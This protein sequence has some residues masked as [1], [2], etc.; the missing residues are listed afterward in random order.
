MRILVTGGAGFIGSHVVDRLL[1]SGHTVAVIDDLSTGLQSNLAPKAT[2]LT[3][4]I[5]LKEATCKAVAGYRPDAIFHLAA[6]VSVPKSFESPTVDADVNILGTLNLLEAVAGLDIPPRFVFI[7]SGGAVYGDALELPSTERTPPNPATP[8]GVAKLAAE[9]Y[10]RLLSPGPSIILRLANVYGPRQG[11]SKE[12][13]VCAVFSKQMIAGE[14]LTIYGDGSQTRDYVYVTDVARACEL[15]L[16]NGGGEVINVSTGVETSAS[17]LA[18]SLL[19]VA[20]KGTV[21]H[22]APRTGDVMRS[23]LS[24]SHARSVLNWA[25]EVSL[26]EGLSETLAARR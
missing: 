25:P 2:L 26:G 7:S 20:G 9:Y 4:D 16:A 21:D 10:V 18:Q 3:V 13:G 17:S 24:P 5:T 1:A 23:C 15:A 22:L 11:A 14:A 12:T 8:Y 19:Q 6:Q